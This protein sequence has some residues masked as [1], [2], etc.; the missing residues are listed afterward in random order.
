MDIKLSL[1]GET[2][3]SLARIERVQGFTMKTHLKVLGVD[4]KG[5]IE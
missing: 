1:M 4:G 3:S 2:S 5:T